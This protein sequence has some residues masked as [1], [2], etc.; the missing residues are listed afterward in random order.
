MAVAAVLPYRAKAAAQIISIAGKIPKNSGTPSSCMQRSAALLFWDFS[1]ADTAAAA[2]AAAAAAV[3]HRPP[4][5][6]F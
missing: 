3:H 6:Q 2:A 1:A 5:R 4:S